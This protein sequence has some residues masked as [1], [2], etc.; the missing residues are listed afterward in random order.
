MHNFSYLW[1]YL[2]ENSSKNS[3][4]RWIYPNNAG[5][6]ESIQFSSQIWWRRQSVKQAVFY[7]EPV[8]LFN[9]SKAIHYPTA[10]KCLKMSIPYWTGLSALVAFVKQI[11]KR[12][13]GRMKLGKKVDDEMVAN[14]TICGTD[15][16]SS[17]SKQKDLTEMQLS[18][19]L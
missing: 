5:Q 2:V 6:T 14:L 15:K 16:I 10:R 9:L 11:W 1:C 17:M 19:F 18:S 7:F 13:A 4:R 3:C 12:S 8:I